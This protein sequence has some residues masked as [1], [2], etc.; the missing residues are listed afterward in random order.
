MLRHHKVPMIFNEAYRPDLNGSK[1][2]GSLTFLVEYVWKQAKD[3][4]RRRLASLRARREHVDHLR[5]VKESMAT[6]T[7]QYARDC[8]ARGIRH[9]FAAQPI[10]PEEEV[11]VVPE[12]LISNQFLNRIVGREPAVRQLD[13]STGRNSPV[14]DANLPEQVENN[15]IA[16]RL[17]LDQMSELDPIMPL[18]LID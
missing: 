5:L 10:L 11:G 9:V 2:N 13:F 14:D 3:F 17:T 8:I 12:P 16:D 6:V 15:T 4:Y 7:Q 1:C 18:G